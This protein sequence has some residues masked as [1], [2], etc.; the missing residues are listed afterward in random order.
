MPASLEEESED[1]NVSDDSADAD[2]D[3]D[4]DDDERQSHEE[5]EGRHR[6]CRRRRR[7]QPVSESLDATE[8]SEPAAALHTGCEADGGSDW[9]AAPAAAEVAAPPM[10][11]PAPPE[12]SDLLFAID[13][14]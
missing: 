1:D 11:Q 2:D 3:G 7:R 12:A 13:L 5:G 10:P 6:A 8:E 4:D 14:R 9:S